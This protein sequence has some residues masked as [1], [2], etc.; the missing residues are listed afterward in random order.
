M[1]L[2]SACRDC[3]GRLTAGFIVDRTDAGELVSNWQEGVPQ[4]RWWTLGGIVRGGAERIEITT[5]RCEG[6]GSLQSFALQN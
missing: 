2:P 1:K 3:G 4:K 5:L 6:C